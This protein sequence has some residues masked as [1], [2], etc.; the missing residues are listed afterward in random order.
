MAEK[1]YCFNDIR[2]IPQP[3]NSYWCW[4]ACL[5]QIIIGLNTSS[6]LGKKQC[7][8]VSAYKLNYKEASISNPDELQICCGSG[9]NIPSGCNIP[10]KKEDLK[11]V[12]DECGLLASELVDLTQL[13]NFSFIKLTLRTFQAP[14]VLNVDKDGR[15]HM[16]LITGYGEKNHCKY[17]LVTDPLKHI[18]ESYIEFNDFVNSISIN[19]AWTIHLRDNNLK[20][21]EA[22]HK[23]LDFV[24]SFLKNNYSRIIKNINENDINPEVILNKWNYLSTDDS[25]LVARIINEASKNIKDFGSDLIFDKK[26]KQLF[27]LIDKGSF[28][29]NKDDLAKCHP[30][31]NKDFL[32][33]IDINYIEEETLNEGMRSNNT[34]SLIERIDEGN[35]FTVIYDYATK[36]Q[37]KSINSEIL[38]KP[39][40]YPKNYSLETDWKRYGDFLNELAK[41]PK[42]QFFEN[43][44]IRPIN[45]GGQLAKL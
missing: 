39:I 28:N 14:I 4:A 31:Y 18:G 19:N 15:A 44:E 6:K 16:N 10:L 2:Y 11:S 22:L 21:D 1:F 12:Y 43:D 29:K 45:G 20:P 30:Y 38:V 26:L 25:P 40:N 42:V 35:A 5:S 8:L 41:N 36:L 7:E 9:K 24:E 34:L 37:L 32:N 33:L 13:Q 3:K 27:F 23:S 17:V